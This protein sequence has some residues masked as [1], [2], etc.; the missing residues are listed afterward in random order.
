MTPL[1]S[2][3][4]CTRNRPE[5][6][7]LA[8]ES[9]QASR[10]E[11]RQIVVSDDSTDDRTQRMLAERFPFVTYSQGPRQGLGANRNHALTQVSGSHVLFMDDDARLAPE[12][13]GQMAAVLA[14]APDAD[15]LIIT[16]TEI[17]RGERV[18]PHKQSF[19]GFQALDYAPDETLYSIVINATVF[20]AS[21][22]RALR[23]DPSLVYGYEE[24]DITA[25]AVLRHGF[26]VRL[27][28][29][30][31]N[32]HFPSAVNR[33]FYAPFTEASRIYVTFKKYYFLER[34]HGKA[35]LFLLAA[36]LHNLAHNLRHR[37]AAGL[38][39]CRTTLGTSLTYI[40]RCLRAEA[41]YV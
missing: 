29:A 16:G 14:G 13:L 38:K 34:R 23:F 24:I 2:V 7:A 41:A 37:G 35:V 10:R 12:F 20:P 30:A 26:S 32:L 18:F 15:R 31:A 25:R 9:V 21:L 27:A 1:F 28:P 3:V 8:I 22:F 5:D 19:L 39:A 40:G 33:E 6:V 11:A 36:S 4:I 17:N